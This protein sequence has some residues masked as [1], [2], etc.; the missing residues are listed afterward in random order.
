MKDE[1]P[2]RYEGDFNGSSG[3]LQKFMHRHGLSLRRTTSVSQKDPDLLIAKVVSF[4]LRIRRLSAKFEYE[5]CDIIA[6]DETPVWS[7]MVSN[8]TVDF[9]GVKSVSMKSTGHEKCRVTVGLS[10]KGDGTKLKPIIVFKD[11]KKAVQALQ[12]EYKSKC[13]VASSANGW[14][15]TD[16]TLTWVREVLGSLSFRKRL[17]V[18]DTYKCHL[19]P[20]V[21]ASLRAKKI[22]TG[23]V[24]GGC[25]PH[26][27]APDVSWNKPFK[28][29]CAEKYDTWMEEVGIHCETDA[30][31]LKPPP[32][33]AIVQWVLD[34]WKEL[35]TELIR[36]SF[37][38]CALTT[39]IDG[40]DDDQI[41]CLR[42]GQPCEK[43]REMLREQLKLINE[44]EDNPF[45][46]D[47]EDMDA[48]TPDE[49]QIDR[50][51]DSDDDDVDVET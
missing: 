26:I 28:A 4:I 46:P 39:A 9:K 27:Q 7:D 47:A 36:K 29:L 43:G 49:I 15:D 22:D 51:G 35:P 50:D 3:W 38:T 30:G 40:S 6:F 1:N 32:P 17:L 5:P 16:L 13:V 42:K 2:D 33:S 11:A 37:V 12:K 24:P 41:N 10:A 31:N 48:A 20:V 23:M 34:A 14:M 18:W 45:V 44:V 19:M 25:T 8:T 21:Q